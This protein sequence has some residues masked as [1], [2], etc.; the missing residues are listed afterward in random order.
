M[1]SLKSQIRLR[2]KT[3][4]EAH[5]SGLEPMLPEQGWREG[6]EAAELTDSSDLGVALG[7]DTY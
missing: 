4:M 6:R 5:G 3:A 1:G 2:D 7:P